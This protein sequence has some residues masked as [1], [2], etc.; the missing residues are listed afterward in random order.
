M[1]INNIEHIDE[2]EDIMILGMEDIRMAAPYRELDFFQIVETRLTQ[3]YTAFAAYRRMTGR[4][5]KWLINLYKICNTVYRPFSKHPV[6][7]FGVPLPIEPE[8][9]DI[10]HFFTIDEISDNRLVL[11]AEDRRLDIVTD[12]RIEN[13]GKTLSLTTSVKT[14]NLSGK[15]HM[16]PIA[17]MHESIV[18]SLFRNLRTPKK[19]T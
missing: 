3:P 19:N 8:V 16:L 11:T 17:L 7:C 6:D 2:E 9:G 18:K 13:E 14:H 15:I 1:N 5:P 4:P 10:L 12:I